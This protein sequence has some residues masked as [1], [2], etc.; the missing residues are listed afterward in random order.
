MNNGKFPTVLSFFYK[1]KQFNLQ[2]V[3][4][5]KLERGGVERRGGGWG[6]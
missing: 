2:W 1:I 4:L 3:K 5:V 6:H